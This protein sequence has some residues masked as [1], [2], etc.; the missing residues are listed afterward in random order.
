MCDFNSSIIAK[1]VG[2]VK[3]CGIGGGGIMFMW[4]MLFQ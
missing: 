2:V 4:F 3:G 1:I